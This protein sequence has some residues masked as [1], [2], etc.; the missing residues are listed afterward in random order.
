[1]RAL[2]VSDVHSNLEAFEAALADAGGRG[3]Y[4]VVWFLG[5]L[6]GYGADPGACIERLRSLPHL[7]VAGN[8]DHAVTGR[9]NPDL[10]NGAARAAALW[11]AERLSDD[12]RDYLAGLPEVRTV[13]SFTHVHGSL[14]DPVMEYLISEPAAVATFALLATPFCL[15]G[16]SHY[17]IVWT[18]R[19]GG[20]DVALLDAT[21]PLALDAGRRVIVNPGS[22]GQPRDGDWRASYLVYDDGVGDVGRLEHYRVEYDIGAAQRKIREAGLPEVLAERLGRGH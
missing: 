20:A 11:T 10:F 15:V 16:H 9:L 3:G 6:V 2:I 4:D 13:G 1:M 14:R 5:D 22:V 17:P 18:E 8:H 12:E 19:E 7:A 21:E